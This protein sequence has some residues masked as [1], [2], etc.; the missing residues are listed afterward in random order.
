MLDVIELEGLLLGKTE[1]AAGS[2]DD[3]VRAVVLEDVAVGLDGDTA[4]E[5]GGLDLGKVLG[6]TLVLV[7]DLEG[8]LASV[9][10]DQDGN[11]VLTGGEGAG[12]KLVQSGQ[13]EDG[14]LTHTGLGLA[15]DVHA[16]DG[17]GDAL[18]LDLGG[19]LETAIDDGAEAFGLED[20]ILETGGMDT[21]IVTFLDLLAIS[22][23]GG[24][25]GGVVGFLLL[26]VVD[27][28]LIVLSSISH[29]FANKSV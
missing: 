25:L 11:L 18:V 27:E 14:R 23:A 19:M 17:L 12:V 4:V 29:G 13:D 20:E 2:A 22:L 3:D 24:L 15:N 21:Y 6:E 16:E 26:V 5:D 10:K 1:D 8:K 9:A 7:G 28:L